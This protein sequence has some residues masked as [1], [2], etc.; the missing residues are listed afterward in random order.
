MN[1]RAAGAGAGAGRENSRQTLRRRRIALIVLLAAPVGL[2]LGLIL[3][4]STDLPSTDALVSVKP[5]EG[6][7]LYDVKNRPIKAFYEEDRAVISLDEMPADLVSAFIAVEDRQFY[8]HWGLNLLA[9]AKALSEDVAARKVVRGASTITQQLA[10]NLFLTQEQTL[11][12]KIKEAILAIRIEHHYTK[13]EILSM[14]LNQIYFGDGAYGVE[15]AAHRF[16]GKGVAD[17]SL[18]ESAMLAGLPRN[19]MAYSPRRH[20]DKAKARQAIVLSSMRAMG[21]ISGQA[22]AEAAR[23]D[24]NILMTDAS[25]P[26]SYFAEYIRQIL[27]EK[28]GAAVLYRE[29]L[30]IYTTLDLD[31]QRQ[32]ES[33][34]ERNLQTLER[35]L[36]YPARGSASTKGQSGSTSTR[37]VQGALVAI[38]PHTGYLRAMVGGRDFAESNWNRATQAQRQPGSAF[39]IFVYTAAVDNGVTP[40]DIL[41]DDPLVVKTPEGK[42]WR[43]QNYDDE[44][45]GPVIARRALARSIN[46]PAIKLA[47]KIGQQTVINYAHR[48][49]VKSTLRPYMSIALGTLEVN[50]LE[51]TSAVGVLANGGIRVE[52]RAI[53]RIESRDGR[54]LERVDVRKSDVLSPQTAYVMTSMLE[55]V[56][57]EGTAGSIRGQGITQSLAGKTGTTDDYSDAWFVGYSPDIVVGTWVGFDTRRRMGEKISGARA[58]LPI[59]ITFMKDVLGDSPDR[60]F[61]EP[62]GIAHRVICEETGFLAREECPTKRDEVFIEGTEPSRACDEHHGDRV[63]QG[64]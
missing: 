64:L 39:K 36:R 13:K 1:G 52:P 49:G 51:L 30:K 24:V 27:E 33:A 42:E 53:L 2:A 14:Y 48:M 3:W 8:R 4:F 50:L 10:R 26:G 5:W 29:G 57:N 16:F 31:L 22:A 34:V 60:P 15:A 21:M 35:Q 23:E 62:A 9:I 12:R 58:A 7:V 17:L 18:A 11:T 43:P 59:W 55:S 63:E 25:E 44:Y 45:L 32:A 47:D 56:V 37:Y 46:I 40:A 19:P 38:D 6:T 28:Y 41:I 20:F 61:L 54:T